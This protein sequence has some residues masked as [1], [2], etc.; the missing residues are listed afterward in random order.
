MRA[1]LL[2]SLVFVLFLV[3]NLAVA[4]LQPDTIH[5]DAVKSLLTLL[6][7]SHY[8]EQAID[9]KLSAKL[10]DRY[11]DTLDPNHSYLLAQDIASFQNKRLQLDE[12][13]DAG[14]LN[15]AYAIYSVF[16]DRYIERSNYLI[17]KLKQDVDF[18]FNSDEQVLISREGKPWFDSVAE[19]DAYWD[20]RLKSAL[21]NL[22]LADRTAEEAT[23]TLIKRYTSQRDRALQTNTEDI[24]QT[25][26]NVLAGTYDPHTSYFSPQTSENFQINMSLSLEG[27]GA[28]LQSEDEYTKVVSLVPAGPA[29]KSGQ[30]K[31]ADLIVGAGQGADGEIEDII[32]MRLDDV[33]QKIRG[34][35][36]S[37][38]R[39]EIIPSTSTDRSTR[40]I[41]SLTRNRVELEEQA[42]QSRIIDVKRDG[43]T[44]KLG[45]IEIPTFYIDFEALQQGD[46]NYR[47]TTRDVSRL[48]TELKSKSIDGLL[49]D[50]RNNGGGSLRE[51]NEL[52]GLFISRGPTVQIR[53]AGG[54][55]DI[56]GDYDPK[57]LW[58]GP[59]T[60][61]VNRLSASA[62]EIF[63][64]AIQ[65][66]RRGLIVG[67]QTFG[68][69]TV[70]TLQPLQ[71][72]QAKLTT[73]K[74]YRISGE[75]TQN[76]GVSPDI[77]FPAMIDHQEIGESALKDALPWD[78][79]RPVRY[80]RYTSLDRWLPELNR[81][82]LQR[83]DNDPDFNLMRAQIEAQ[84]DQKQQLYLPLNEQKLRHQREMMENRQ[85]TLENQ[86]RMARNQPPIKT[87]DELFSEGET[88]STSQK[89][90]DPNGEAI[91][92]EAGELTIDMIEM[93][94]REQSQKDKS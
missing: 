50:L 16:L 44:Y 56:L 63:A 60:V 5:T 68:K 87:L 45:V 24:Y 65:D 89:F 55:V 79:V 2:K 12:E 93:F 21:L 66:Y 18:N 10:F 59:L 42:A 35:K 86:R 69:G 6:A 74:F 36:D 22:K 67:S 29:D 7:Q 83:T 1:P 71:H 92:K 38:V 54:R 80:S 78:Q 9:D 30:I 4:K 84:Q 58:T 70:Q 20:R 15:T 41:I 33:V 91:L 90:R 37:V 64:G 3:S 61:V 81:R 27:I 49:I 28:V 32:G 62:S 17:D 46:P 14:K 53:D 47:S 43:K 8:R 34:P 31:P 19:Q 11:L 94:T 85:L 48:I 13:L 77:K 57:T 72:G 52:I 73:A 26:T 39:L 76:Q 25:F 51:A 88:S 82:H 23:Q 40:K 75:S